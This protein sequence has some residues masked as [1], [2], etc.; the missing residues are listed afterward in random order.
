MTDPTPDHSVVEAHIRGLKRRD[1]L[2]LSAVAAGLVAGSALLRPGA[3][4]AQVPEGIA[5]MTEGEYAVWH[6]LMQVLLPTEGSTL[7]PPQD[8]PVMQTVD[9]GFLAGMPPHVLAVV[10]GGVAYFND[11]AEGPFG[12][13]FVDLSD[14]DATAWCDALASSDEAPA[15]GLF[16][17]L[18]FLVVTAYWAIPPAWGPIG[19]DGPVT[20]AWGLEYQGNAPLPQA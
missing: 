5:H 18:K 6:R 19:F 1:F 8:L 17:A 12:A 10:K 2:R 9:A 15:R 7:V 4:L 3:A 11:A 20:E 14:A 16:S 13:K